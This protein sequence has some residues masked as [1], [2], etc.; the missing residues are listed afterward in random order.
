[1]KKNFIIY[2]FIIALVLLLF[3]IVYPFIEIDT[4]SKIIQF[5]YSDSIDE[6]DE[7]TC[8]DESYS[9]NEERNITI[10]NFDFKKFLFFHVISVTYEE[11]NRCATE[12]YLE[13]SYI[14]NFL[15]N[16][17]IKYNNNNID[18]AKLIE[19]R[20]A[21]TGNIRYTGNDYLNQID[22]ILEG[23]HQTLFVFYSE[24]LLIIQ[25]GLS[26]EG[27]KFIAYKEIDESSFIGKTWTREGDGDTEVLAF[28]SNGHFTYYCMCGNP[29]YD[30]DIYE[31]YIY[32]EKE[33]IITL[34]SNYSANTKIIK[35]IS[36]SD[37][38]LKIDFDG[39]IRTFGLI[40]EE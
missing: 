21:V 24:D 33:N 22:Y 2:I 13:K 25:V 17:E 15:E 36:Y 38:E 40:S 8:Y 18:I 26:D 3:L 11:G 28:N 35:I 20:V 14:D 23:K 5:R 32:N 9:Y 27:P 31:N 30:S 6:F 12:Y 1:M 29:V 7:N 4:G 10:L 19:G 39:D 16:A 37:T 34:V